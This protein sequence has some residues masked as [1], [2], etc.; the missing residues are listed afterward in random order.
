[1]GTR[2]YSTEL[3]A[4]QQQP[5]AEVDKPV[6]GRLAPLREPQKHPG[7]YRDGISPV[8]IGLNLRRRVMGFQADRATRY[9]GAQHDIPNLPSSGARQDR[10][11]SLGERIPRQRYVIGGL[12]GLPRQ[13]MKAECVC[14]ACIQTLASR[15]KN[16]PPG[17]QTSLFPIGQHATLREASY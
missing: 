2:P 4:V 3:G 16:C 17:R 13:T 1:M 5:P 12:Y 6:C 10:A 15:Y 8:T 7:V 14:N 11:D 9:A